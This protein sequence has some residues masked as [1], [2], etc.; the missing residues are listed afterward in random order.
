[1]HDVVVL[2]GLH[3]VDGVA[4]ARCLEQIP[5]VG[6]Q[7]RHLCE[8]RPIAFEV[9]VIYGVKSGQCGEQPDVC[10]GDGV[11]YEIALGL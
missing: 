2:L 10:L 1:M 8:F 7:R 3:E 9:A 4:K 6:P 5:R 11:A